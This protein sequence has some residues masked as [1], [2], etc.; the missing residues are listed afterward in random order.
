MARLSRKGPIVHTGRLRHRITLYRPT[1]TTDAYGQTIEGSTELGTYW[2]DVLP[3]RST[4]GP[5]PAGERL[6][7]ETTH[8]VTIRPGPTIEPGDWLVW[9]GLRLDLVGPPR[10]LEGRSRRVEL[11]CLE[12]HPTTGA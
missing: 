5:S 6:E 7:A 2:A 9:R 1:I 12:H 8:L 10:D 3:V 11:S 4:E